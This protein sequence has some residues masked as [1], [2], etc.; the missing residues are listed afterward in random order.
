MGFWPGLGGGE[1]KVCYI[2]EWF[3]IL[4]RWSEPWLGLHMSQDLSIMSQAFS[5]S[6]TCRAVSTDTDSTVISRIHCT[7]LHFYATQNCSAIS[8]FQERLQKKGRH[9]CRD[10]LCWPFETRVRSCCCWSWESWSQVAKRQEGDSMRAGI[11]SSHKPQIANMKQ[12]VNVYRIKSCTCPR[13]CVM[14]QELMRSSLCRT[15]WKKLFK[16]SRGLRTRQKLLKTSL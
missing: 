2:D 4:A 15:S 10:K 6:D 3:P 5:L 9:G 16:R 11:L 13:N 7:H 12:N 1:G 14:V 8:L